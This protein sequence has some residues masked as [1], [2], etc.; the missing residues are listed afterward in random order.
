MAAAMLKSIEARFSTFWLSEIFLLRVNSEFI[1]VENGFPGES[2][3]AGIQV[4]PARCIQDGDPERP[5]I[6][7]LN[8]I[9]IASQPFSITL[10]VY[11]QLGRVVTQYSETVSEQEFRSVVQGP[12][13]M[14]YS[15]ANMINA[16]AD[17][18]MP[19]GPNDF[20]KLEFRYFGLC[21]GVAIV[22]AQA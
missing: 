4:A 18:R 10:S 16:S 13:F 8:F 6:N 5:S 17:C 11:D 14:P 19:V 9:M 21:Q 2:S 7:C 3:V 1:S 22:K 12:T 20:G 15:G